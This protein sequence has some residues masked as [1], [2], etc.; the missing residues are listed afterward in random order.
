MPVTTKPKPRHN[1]RR[2]TSYRPRTSSAPRRRAS[3]KAGLN[4]SGAMKTPQAVWLAGGAFAVAAITVVLTAPLLVDGFEALLRTFGLCLVLLVAG[5]AVDTR[6][7]LRRPQVDQRLLRLLTGSHLLG[8]F[9]F[10]AA[11]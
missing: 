5:V 2:A 1:P 3:R 4:L 7:A 11:A 8:L 9:A 10:G 6:I